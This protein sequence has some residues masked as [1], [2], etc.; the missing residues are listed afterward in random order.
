MPQ[1]ALVIRGRILAR[2]LGLKLLTLDADI[3]TAPQSW[4]GPRPP[5]PGPPE[6][7]R[8]EAGLTGTGRAEA[9]PARRAAARPGGLRALPGGPADRADRAPGPAASGSARFAG[10]AGDAGD[11]RAHTGRAVPGSGIAR[12]RQLVKQSA[13]ALDEGPGR[14]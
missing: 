1:E 5:E 9:A 4:L 3:V 10:D 2:L 14:P 13:R 6:A 11:Q 8:A 12:A 7:G